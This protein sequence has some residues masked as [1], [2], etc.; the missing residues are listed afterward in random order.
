MQLV[1]Q[2]QSLR[3]LGLEQPG[4]RPSSPAHRSIAGGESPRMPGKGLQR[5][6][7]A[8]GAQPVLCDRG[9]DVPTSAW[10]RLTLLWSKGLSSTA[11]FGTWHTQHSPP[12]AAGIPPSP[13]AAGPPPSPR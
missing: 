10:A 9:Q 11:S 5:P 7:Q 6:F 8:A 2:G 3:Y 1:L 12:K 4:C 13:R